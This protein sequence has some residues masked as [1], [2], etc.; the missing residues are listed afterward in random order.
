M[1][2]RWLGRKYGGSSQNPSGGSHKIIERNTN[3]ARSWRVI[4]PLTSSVSPGHSFSRIV[5]QICRWRDSSRPIR[6]N[7]WENTGWVVPD[8]MPRNRVDAAISPIMKL[9]NRTGVGDEHSAEH[10]E[11]DDRAVRLLGG[12]AVRRHPAQG[13]GGGVQDGEL[14]FL[15]DRRQLGGPHPPLHRVDVRLRDGG[16]RPEPALR[17]Y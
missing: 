11:P 16:R 7:I 14:G 3:P 9:V 15:V 5:M 6:W 2:T 12:E 13:Q 10:R 1:S 8:D 4:R 17:D